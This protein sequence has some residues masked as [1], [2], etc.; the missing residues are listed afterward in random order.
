MRFAP[1]EF[2]LAKRDRLLG[3]A[4][5]QQWALRFPLTR[6][7]ARRRGR[8]LFDLC[9]GFVYSQVLLACVRL[10]LFELLETG[11]RP[12]D[13]L[14]LEMGLRPDGAL[15]L[16]KAAAALGLVEWRGPGHMCGLGRHG[17]ALLG[18]RG[19]AQ[20]I[21]HHALLYSDLQDPVAV[22]RRAGAPARLEKFWAYA[23][24]AT[25]ATSSAEQVGRYTELMSAS[26][27]FIAAEVLDAYD[28]SV[29]QCLLDIGGGD[30]TF[31]VAAAERA[32]R[33]SFMCFDLPAVAER[34]AVR[35][36]RK[37][38]ATRATAVGGDFLRQALPRGAD[39]ISIVRVLH[40]HGDEA[41]LR[42]LKSAYS[43]LPAN[44]TLLIAEP[45][46]GTPGGE[47]VADAYFGFYLLAMGSGKPRSLE[48]L[49]GLLGKAGFGPPSLRPTR[50]PMNV[51]VLLAKKCEV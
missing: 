9:A 4:A 18:N 41:V 50:M 30:G 40:D 25:P 37:G 14:A 11:P 8:E 10:R 2:A 38:L 28:F 43:A 51:R 27:S 1:P 31:C 46:S 20:L 19:L 45:I 48:E 13:W 49:A 6:W 5:F 47:R 29:H 3:S 34:A 26:Q 21:E 44:G 15:T 12:V 42:I 22:L 33:L 36:G 23:A 24:T 32:P 17:A 7:I 16:L 35:F 39:V